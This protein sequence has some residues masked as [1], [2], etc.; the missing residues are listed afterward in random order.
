MGTSSISTVGVSRCQSS[1]TSHS[2]VDWFRI[3][4]VELATDTEGDAARDGDRLGV[5]GLVRVVHWSFTIFVL[6]KS[7]GR[8]VKKI[9]GSNVKRKGG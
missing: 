8:G 6:F 2:P 7:M 3:Y 4:S 5:R 9:N 1:T